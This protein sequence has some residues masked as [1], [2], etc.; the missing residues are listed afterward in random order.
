MLRREFLLAGLATQT[1]FT[2]CSGNSNLEERYRSYQP[3]LV[4]NASSEQVSLLISAKRQ[5]RN[6]E[7]SAVFEEQVR[8]N[9]S[10]SIKYENAIRLPD[11]SATFDIIA[12]LSNRNEKRKT[13]EQ[14]E[15]GSRIK[16]T[17]E[18]ESSVEII[19]E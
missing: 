10:E 13:F 14:F 1:L 8:L 18:S 12:T 17:I 19:E 6:S 7:P 3:I 9:S 11:Y 5:I 15:D 2:G 16:I 4:S